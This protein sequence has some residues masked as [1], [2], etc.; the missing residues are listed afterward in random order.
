MIRNWKIKK[1]KP[2][3]SF[4]LMLNVEILNE[5]QN[6]I[7]ELVQKDHFIVEHHNL[8]VQNPHSNVVEFYH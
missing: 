2:K 3:E 6:S 8:K 7:L 1:N 5:S 4:L